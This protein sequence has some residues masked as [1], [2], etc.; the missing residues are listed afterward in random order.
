MEG[1]FDC[2]I[3]F[4]GDADRCLA[5]DELGPEIDGDK[6]IALLAVSMKEKGRLDGCLL[7]TSRC[8]YE[9][10]LIPV[11]F[12]TRISGMFMGS[13]LSLSGDEMDE[14]SFPY[15]RTLSSWN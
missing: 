7:Y 5:C 12:A 4:D 15:A 8:V 13:L 3:A 6:V 1:G 10:G 14:K 2:G 9:T 11:P